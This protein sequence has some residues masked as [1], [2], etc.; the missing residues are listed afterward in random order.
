MER[1]ERRQNVVSDYTQQ[2]IS[3]TLESFPQYCEKRC[4]QTCLHDDGY[5]RRQ[6]FRLEH[7][8]LARPALTVEHAGDGESE[9]QHED[10][11]ESG[12]HEGQDVLLGRQ[13]VVNGVGRGGRVERGLSLQA[14]PQQYQ[15]RQCSVLSSQSSTK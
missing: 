8:E 13:Q 4:K 2:L 7:V 5:T 6:R 12:H 9:Q 11:D 14:G 15:L 1:T 3:L 10:D